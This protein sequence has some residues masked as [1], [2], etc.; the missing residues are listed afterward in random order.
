MI[1]G[2]FR[3][4][5]VAATTAT[6]GCAADT[7]HGHAH[8]SLKPSEAS[9]VASAVARPWTPIS[10]SPRAHATMRRAALNTLGALTQ[11]VEETNATF[12]GDAI[13]EFGRGVRKVLDQTAMYDGGWVQP[14][15]ET[16]TPWII[17]LTFDDH[18]LGGWV[19]VGFQTDGGEPATLVYRPLWGDPVTVDAADLADLQCYRSGACAV[20]K[21]AIEETIGVAAESLGDGGVGLYV[22]ALDS[23]MDRVAGGAV[24]DLT[25]ASHELANLA[26]GDS[27]VVFTG[28]DATV[29]RG[30]HLVGPNSMDAVVSDS[31]EV[32]RAVADN[33]WVFELV[34]DDGAAV[35][36]QVH[37]ATG[38]PS[39]IL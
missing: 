10:T 21:D 2:F 34:V 20:V 6:L 37:A 26:S 13:D 3:I 33:H 14:P 30:V 24:V 23:D 19:Y 17:E 18:V 15:E 22:R 38:E 32:A 8:E 25:A 5:M 7:E 1:S 28:T 27:S 9:A 29:I 39:W 11:L 31:A 35:Y 12:H 4:A 36:V 16:T